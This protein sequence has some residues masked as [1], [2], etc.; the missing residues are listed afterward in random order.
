MSIKKNI[1][2]NSI[3]TVSKYIVSLLTFSYTSR[4]LGIENIGILGF[5][6]NTI[7]YFILFST[8]GIGIIGARDIAKNQNDNKN[9]QIVFSSLIILS[10]I[11]TILVLFLFFLA[12]TYIPKLNNYK[13]LFYLGF[14]KILFSVFIIEWFYKGSEK[15]KYISLGFIGINI[16][17]ISSVFLFVKEKD[18][19][20]I[21]YFLTIGAVVINSIMNFIYSRKFVKFNFWNIS[22][23]N[24]LSQTFYLGI[25]SILTATY[26]TFNI[27]YLGLESDLI[28]IGYYWTAIKIYNVAIGIFGAF[29]SVMMP[30]MSTLHSEGNINKFNQM[31]SKSFDILF[32]ISIPLVIFTTILSPQ[33]ISL[34]SGNGFEGAVISMR[35][36]MPLVIVVGIAQILVVQIL[37]PLLKDKIIFNAS[38]FGAIF[39]ISLNIILVKRFGSTG[40]AIVLFFSEISITLYYMYKI[41]K[42]K[43]FDFSKIL[44]NNKLLYSIP[45]IFICF[46]A[47]KL[48]ANNN[49]QLLLASIL[50]FSYLLV[51]QIFFLK[52]ENAVYYWGQLKQKFN[53]N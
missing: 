26:T 24:Y 46:A 29:T 20:I 16:F 18:D 2:Y 38:I 1:G 50:S 23:K 36:I 12:I 7:N 10:L 9:L 17:Y 14:A 52:Q 11:F 33:I 35:I 37:I 8:M 6:D 44:L 43:I 39:G 22:L 19:L 45:Y 5:V 34:I 32:T 53:R 15:F 31:I 40:T 27:I 48:F 3:L 30:R 13:E 51:S 21:Y 4:I 49:Y 25:Y 47:I 42:L 28:N 41:S